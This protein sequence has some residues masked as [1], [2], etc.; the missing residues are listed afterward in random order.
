MQDIDPTDYEIIIVDDAACDDTRMQVEC[1]IEHAKGCGH[2]IRYFPVTGSH[3]PA[4]ARNLGWRAAH[5]EII[6]FTDDD[7]LPNPGWLQA[8]L[9][10]FHE[11]IVGVSGKTIVP[12]EYTPTDY[13]R[14]AALLAKAEFVTANCFYR[15]DALSTVG[16][17]DEHFTMAWREDSDLVFRL[18]EQVSPDGPSSLVYAP[19]AVVIHPVRPA[20][21]GASLKQQRK[22]MFNAL[23][24]KKHPALYRQRIQATPPWHYYCILGALLVALMSAIAGYWLFALGALCAWILMTG[25]FCLLRLDHT[26]HSLCH[27]SEMIVTSIL[28]PLLAIF[29]RIAGAIR[30]RVFFL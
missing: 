22:S 18:L 11:G 17:F 3:G 5:G 10:A 9:A 1:W 6:A 15:R 28:I 29:W 21:W 23:L 30:F 2:T 7:C 24:Y 12:V 27:I 20:S 16:G 26:S 14:N 19:K 8:G 25:R 4:A 13:E